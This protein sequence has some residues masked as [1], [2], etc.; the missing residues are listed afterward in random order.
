[1]ELPQYP[2]PREWRDLQAESAATYDL[3][4]RTWVPEDTYTFTTQRVD[5]DLETLTQPKHQAA[6]ILRRLQALFFVTGPAVPV[7]NLQGQA[8]GLDLSRLLQELAQVATDRD[9]RVLSCFAQQVLQASLQLKSS[10]PEYPNERC[11]FM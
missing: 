6:F 4:K 3:I 8:I 1:M 7:D 11:V 5:A 2:K 10:S 9:A